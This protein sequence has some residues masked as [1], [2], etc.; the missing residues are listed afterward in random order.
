MPEFVCRD[1]FEE[2]T[3][4]RDAVINEDPALP[5]YKFVVSSNVSKWENRYANIGIFGNLYRIPASGHALVISD[6][7][8]D[9]MI[10]CFQKVP[11][12]F[13][14]Y[15]DCTLLYFLSLFP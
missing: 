8:A 7:P 13:Y 5:V 11:P 1:Y 14:S 12:T 4:R 9:F 10:D 6:Q 3:V 2:R 15:L